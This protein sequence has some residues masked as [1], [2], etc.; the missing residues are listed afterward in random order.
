MLQNLFTILQGRQGTLKSVNFCVHDKEFEYVFE[1]LVNSIFGTENVHEYYNEYKYVINNKMYS[2]A[3]LRPDTIMSCS[4]FKNDGNRDINNTQADF[5]VIDAKYYNYGYTNKSNDLPQAS[6][7]AK[8]IGYNYFLKG[9]TGKKFYSVFLLPF[10]KER[11]QDSCFMLDACD[12]LKCVGYASGGFVQNNIVENNM[13]KVAVCL[14]DL[15]ALVDVF[16]N[17]AKDKNGKTIGKAEMRK[18]L[19]EKVSGIFK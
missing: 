7:I 9:K 8:Q 1:F 12:L 14:V 5:F 16:F 17:V 10:A 18:A 4:E 19:W 3:K 13:N 11:T 15:K 6:A 2:A